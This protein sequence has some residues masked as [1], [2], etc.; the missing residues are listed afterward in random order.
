MKSHDE[1]CQDE[2]LHDIL[3]DVYGIK[4]IPGIIIID[5]SHPKFVRQGH[6]HQVYPQAE[7]GIDQTGLPIWIGRK[8]QYP[9]KAVSETIGVARS[10]QYEKRQEGPRPQGRHYRK[11]GDD[12]YLVLIRQIIDERATCGYRRVT[13]YL[14]RLVVRID[15]PRV[16]P[17]WVYRLMKIGGPLLQCSTGRPPEGP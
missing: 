2:D 12:R 6:Y 16:N 17:K 9:M 7:N 10:R 8:G 3:V 14:N 5:A 15:E 13:A 1:T 4:W 11:A